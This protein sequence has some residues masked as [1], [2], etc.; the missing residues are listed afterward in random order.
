M[1]EG[2]FEL[3]RWKISNWL[4]KTVII[5]PPHP[6]KRGDLDI[7]KSVPRAFEVDEL[8][9][10]ESDDRFSEGVVVRV[11]PAADRR[12][13]ALLGQAFGVPNREIL[14]AAIRV[15]DQP[16]AVLPVPQ[17]L[18]KGVERQFARERVEHTPADDPAG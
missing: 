11:T 4:E 9:L 8:G 16:L 18:L 1:V 5:E 3:R 15:M 2:V 14:R 6:L 7:L 13:D 10:V 17:R 12:L